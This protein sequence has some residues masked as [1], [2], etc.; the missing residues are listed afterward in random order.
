MYTKK[1]FSIAVIALAF[2]CSKT[3]SVSKKQSDANLIAGL[4]AAASANATINSVNSSYLEVQGTWSTFTGSGT[5]KVADLYASTEPNKKGVFL[6]NA[7]TY[8]DRYIIVEYDNST[9]TAYF[10]KDGGDG[11]NPNKFG[12]L[13]WTDISSNKFHF[14]YIVNG[15]SSLALAKADTTA[16]NSTTL[17][18]TG[19]GGFAWTRAERQ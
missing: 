15:K 16:A 2:A 3:E 12:R 7:T 18:T 11:F 5:T 8:S 1:I 13:V 19:C 6:E 17:T 14:C 4:L 10:V 9:N